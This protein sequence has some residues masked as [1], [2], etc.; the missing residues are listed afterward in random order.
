MGYRWLVTSLTGTLLRDPTPSP[1]ITGRGS[2]RCVLRLVVATGVDEALA[3]DFI[4]A[5]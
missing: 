4:V 3:I 5:V 1:G 2:L